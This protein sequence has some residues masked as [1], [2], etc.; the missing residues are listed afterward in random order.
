MQDTDVVAHTGHAGLD[1]ALGGGW[2]LGACSEI[3]GDESAGK[4]RLALEA[5]ARAQARGCIPLWLDCDGT[6]TPR[7]CRDAGVDI[8][9]LLVVPPP[10]SLDRA[11]AIVAESLRALPDVRVVVLDAL[12]ALTSGHAQTDATAYSWAVRALA[13][14]AKQRN[15]AVLVIAGVRDRTLTYG[16]RAP[17]MLPPATRMHLGARVEVQMRRVGKTARVTW[18]T[19]SW[20]RQHTVVLD[21]EVDRSRAT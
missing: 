8:A 21:E 15:V 12:H 5:V 10:G 7:H 9:T 3:Y 19:R 4:T 2:P 13:S 11:V 16:E 20:P 6:L 1:D 14:M 17:S 18:N